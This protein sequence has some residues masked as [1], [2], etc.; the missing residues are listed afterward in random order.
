ML[1]FFPRNRPS[2]LFCL[3]NS[4]P[5]IVAPK[6]T[7]NF[8]EYSEFGLSYQVSDIWSILDTLLIIDISECI[9]RRVNVLHQP[10]LFV[11]HTVQLGCSN[12]FPMVSQSSAISLSEVQQFIKSTF[13]TIAWM[14]IGQ[15]VLGL[16]PISTKFSPCNWL[17]CRKYVCFIQIFDNMMS[18]SLWQ[19]ID[20]TEMDEDDHKKS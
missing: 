10:E 16:F 11:L 19:E 12:I 13:R 8:A 5:R 1:T 18:S 6:W 2:P 7:H 14:A 3:L 17:K 4:K 15:R 9:F 20:Q